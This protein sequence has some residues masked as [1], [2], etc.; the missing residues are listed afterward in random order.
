MITVTCCFG[1]GGLSLFFYFFVD[2]TYTLT[3]NIC[4]AL[5][6]DFNAVFQN[7]YIFIR[8]SDSGFMF[9]RIGCRSASSWRHLFTPFSVRQKYGAGVFRRLRP[10]NMG[11]APG[12]Q[13][14]FR[15]IAAPKS[16]YTCMLNAV[17]SYLLRIPQRNP[18]GTG[19]QSAPVSLNLGDSKHTFSGIFSR[20]RIVCSRTCTDIQ[21][22]NRNTNQ[23]G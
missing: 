18:S 1:W 3:N 5:S 16:F 12:P 19:F 21:I 13:Q 9:F 4:F 20:N 17:A 6:R 7:F 2:L 23:K 11:V 10:A 8:H 22:L 15:E 14:P